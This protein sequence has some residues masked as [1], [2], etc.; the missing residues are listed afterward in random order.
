V[1]SPARRR[2]RI[3]ARL[4]IASLLIAAG[5]VVVVMGVSASV[6]GRERQGLPAAIESVTPVNLSEAVPAQTS[7]IVDLQSGFTGELAV[8]GVAIETVDLSDL[9]VLTPQPG[10]QVTLPTA[11]IFE[12]G[13]ATLTFQPTEGAPVEEL[14]QGAH[15]VTVRYWPIEE[16]PQ[17]AR[18]YGWSFT[19]F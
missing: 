16:G 5:V 6:T 9:G 3:D 7:I 18:T 10:E 19:V 2:R 15:R 8:D 1:L 13:N 4:L 17:A 12:P 11:T 14:R